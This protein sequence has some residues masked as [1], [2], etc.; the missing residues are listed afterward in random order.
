MTQRGVAGAI[1]DIIAKQM[2]T[3]NI[4]GLGVALVSDD[5]TIQIICS[6][7]VREK[8][9]ALVSPETVFEAASLTKPVFAAAALQL[10]EAGKLSLDE[11]INRLLPRS[12]LPSDSRVDAITMRHVLSHTTGFPNW[13]PDGEE[14][15]I[16]SE[17]GLRFSYSGEGFQFLQTVV[18]S[19]MRTSAEEF[20]HERV[21]S[22][23]GMSH[24]GLVWRSEYEATAAFP[25]LTDHGCGDYSRFSSAN[26]A[27]SMYTTPADFARFLSWMLDS[28][29][30]GVL[31]PTLSQQMITP[32]I[33]ASLLVSWGLGWG[34]DHSHETRDVFWHWGDNG[35]FKN[36]A[37]GIPTERTGIVVMANGEGALM[38]CLEIC[39]VALQHPLL[40]VERFLSDVY[41]G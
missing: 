21:L 29:N 26:A 37:V 4:P 27:Y 20:L 12:Y 38:G 40:G 14:L 8:G 33:Q 2:A 10:V 17:P 31:S 6:G 18:E 5:G 24:S 9:G 35:G 7:T 23:L 22:P 41:K 1:G 36:L 11:P 39:R 32:A 13:R 30:T 15:T 19:V 16:R 28:K 25:H 3:H 34:L